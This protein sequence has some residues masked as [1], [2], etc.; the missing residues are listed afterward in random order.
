MNNLFRSIHF[1]RSVLYLAVGFVLLASAVLL[2]AMPANAADKQLITLSMH[3]TEL[4]KVM[5]MLS[6][7]QRVNIL[8][9]GDVGGEVSFNLYDVELEQ[10]IRSISAAA[11]YAVEYRDGSYFIV[12]HD[13][14]GKYAPDGIT[15]VKS[16]DVRYAD[17][18]ALEETLRPYLS[19]YGALTLARERR[20]LIV[21]DTPEFV[22]R[23]E[24]LL[25]DLD[26][27]PTQILIE[28][29]ILEVTLDDEESFGVDWSKLFD[30]DGGGGSFGTQGLARAGSAGLFFDFATPNVEATLSALSARGRVRTLS[31]PKLLALQNQEASVIIGDR[32]GYQVT[33]TINQITTESIEFLESG[34]ILRVTPNVDADGNVMLNI[35]PEVSNGSV[36]INGI[37]SQ[38]TTEVTTQLIVPGGQTVFI[39][40]LMKHT[41]S[42]ITSGVPVLGNVPGLGR[43]F[44]NSEK[45][46]VNTETVVLI[47]P[48]IVSN[49][50]ATWSSD[51]RKR[52]EMHDETVDSQL[53]RMHDD[54][55]RRY[56]ETRVDL[57]RHS[58]FKMST[59]MST[60]LSGSEDG[61][62]R[63]ASSSPDGLDGYTL[64][65]FHCY[66][67]GDAQR[68][69]RNH[70][71]RDNLRYYPVNNGNRILVV[72][73]RYATSTEARNALNGAPAEIASMQPI[74]RS[75]RGLFSEGG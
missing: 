58:G 59:V 56:P 57:S 4:S 36:D 54:V 9:T 35:H 64:Y 66:S 25:V 22:A 8:L 41:L 32:R 23:I 75:L 28:A 74:A 16:F 67:A 48:H 42:E 24:N 6:R 37:P 55:N 49:A 21:E 71:Y 53:E 17:A 52:V 39:G 7:Q 43:L 45:T 1:P 11:G 29:K 46:N 60:S 33:T 14:A 3:D 27:R 34:V 10:A 31:T 68:F 20:L 2:S 5:E 65:L 72:Y 30:S 61:L 62:V 15:V 69:I 70:A 47:T 44:S 12:S 26:R 18:D 40:G 19:S 63:S 13:D 50:D 38:T 73:G 51:Q